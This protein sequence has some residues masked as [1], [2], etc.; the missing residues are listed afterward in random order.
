[1]PIMKKLSLLSSLLFFV[2]SLEALTL[3]SNVLTVGVGG[4]YVHVNAAIAITYAF[5]Y[6]LAVSSAKHLIASEGTTAFQPKPKRAYA[7]NDKQ[8]NCNFS[9]V[10]NTPNSYIS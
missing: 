2:N 6:R 10:I 4:Q 8:L 3:P 1:M 9:I 7:G 5:S